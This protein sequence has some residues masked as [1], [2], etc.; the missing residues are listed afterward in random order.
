MREEFHDSGILKRRMDYKNGRPIGQVETY[1][2]SGR[3]I[4]QENYN[5]KGLHGIQRYFDETTPRKE[6]EKEI[7]YLNGV[8][9]G[10]EQN[11]KTGDFAHFEQGVQVGSF[12]ET[13]PHD[14][15]KRVTQGY[16]KDG[17]SHV[18]FLQEFHRDGSLSYQVSYDKDGQIH[19]NEITNSF[20]GENHMTPYNHGVKN[21]VETWK[22][23]RL[24]NFQTWENGK[25]NGSYSYEKTDMGLTEQEQGTYL[26]GQ[27]KIQQITRKDGRNNIVYKATYDEKGNLHGDFI[28]GENIIPYNHGVKHGREQI[29]RSGSGST[30]YTWENGILNGPYQEI[31]VSHKGKDTDNLLPYLSRVERGYYRNGQPFVEEK[32]YYRAEYNDNKGAVS[33]QIS[34]EEYRKIQKALLQELENAKNQLSTDDKKNDNKET[35]SHSS[36]KETLS[37]ASLSQKAESQKKTEPISP[38]I[39]QQIANT[40]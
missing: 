30:F 4:A 34:E 3:L 11:F 24:S 7:S 36:L 25:L 20:M 22:T 9:N 5:E 40:R 35:A 38:G 13:T 18:Q 8:K 12:R 26:S 39:I 19:G 31:S 15:G 1:D 16:I 33:T 27:K 32:S 23:N 29:G 28:D 10:K 14:P 37:Q 21:G 2:D 17:I 6:L